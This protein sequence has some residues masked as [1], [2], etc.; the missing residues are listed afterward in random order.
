[1]DYKVIVDSCGELSKGMKED[2]HFAS[3]PLELDV[4][5]YHVVDDESFCQLEFLEK[6][7][8]SP[9]CPKSACPSPQRYY[10]AYLS[11]AEHVYVVTLSSKLSG[12][13]NSALV[14]KQMFEADFPQ[15]KIHVFDSCSAS[16][17]ETLIGLKLQELEETGH[18]FEETVTLAGQYIESQQ[19]FFVL[20]TLETLRKNGRLSNLKAFV[21]GVLKIKPVMGSTPD[22]QIC[23]LGQAQGMNKALERMVKE[24][25][26]RTTDHSQKLLAI[27]HCNCPKRAQKVKEQIE[28][29]MHFK[30]ILILETAGVS[31][32][33]ANDGGIIV[34]V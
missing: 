24:I 5:G 3:V 12:S 34:A 26:E 10:D 25:A 14:A 17:G 6:V 31:S 7:R 16:V 13:Y 29:A 32:M 4:D 9:N 8:R 20:E 11:D 23:Q 21:A 28:K 19:T 33:Y 2:G 22:G 27:S 15:K 30:Q 1:M 18:T